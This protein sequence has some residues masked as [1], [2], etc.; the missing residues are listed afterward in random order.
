M[1]D[2]GRAVCD[3]TARCPEDI[4]FCCLCDRR[5]PLM[6]GSCDCACRDCFNIT[7]TNEDGS[8]GFCWVCQENHCEDGAACAWFREES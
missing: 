6:T 5:L 2:Q 1:T 7:S 4:T 3:C 8:P